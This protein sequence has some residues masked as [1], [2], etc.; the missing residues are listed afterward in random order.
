MCLFSAGEDMVPKSALQDE[1]TAAAPGEHHADLSQESRRQS[2]GEGRS[3]RL[4][5]RRTC[6]THH[7]PIH[8]HTSRVSPVLAIPPLSYWLK[9]NINV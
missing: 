2:S 4:Q 3:D 8:P 1:E 7:I 6:T 9:E 5:Q